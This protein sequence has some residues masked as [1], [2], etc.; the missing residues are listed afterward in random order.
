MEKSQ[1]VEQM[2]IG[3]GCRDFHIGEFKSQ[4]HYPKTMYMYN[5][6]GVTHI[7]SV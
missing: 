2:L 5:C 6:W 1:S 7:V 3:L 4:I